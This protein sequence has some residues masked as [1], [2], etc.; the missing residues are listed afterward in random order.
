M[1]ELI[2]TALN[3]YADITKTLWFHFTI[4]AKKSGRKEYLISGFI[5]TL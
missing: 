3:I 5:A 2:L 4:R 1:F